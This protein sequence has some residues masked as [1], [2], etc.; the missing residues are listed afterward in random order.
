[1]SRIELTDNLITMMIKLAEGNPGA[2]TACMRL[3]K[4]GTDLDPQALA[5]NGG[6][7]AL[8][9]LDEFGIYG[10]RIWGLY[11]DV[12][13]ESSLKTL[14][15]LRA[16]QLGIITREQLNNVID[17]RGAGLDL[18]EIVKSVKSQLA[19]FGK[20]RNSTPEEPK[21]PEAE[22]ATNKSE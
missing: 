10:S 22:E 20:E 11:K 3:Y 9:N 18:V 8:L 14:G 17:N 2:A 12:C 6:I 1:M 19:D 7:A 4:E 13:N 21:E 15:V 5:G 16:V